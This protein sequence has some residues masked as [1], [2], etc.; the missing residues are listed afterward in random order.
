ME[1]QLRADYFRYD[2]FSYYSIGFKEYII[3]INLL[4]I[5]GRFFFFFCRNIVILSETMTSRIIIS[6]RHIYPLKICITPILIH[7]IS[8]SE[9]AAPKFNPSIHFLYRNRIL[10][11][12]LETN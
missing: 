7:I 8:F 12:V 11:N 6:L 5:T 9:L 10:D 3:L 1:L 4:S 2:L